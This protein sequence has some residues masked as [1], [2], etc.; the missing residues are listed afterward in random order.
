[1][2]LI[3]AITQLNTRTKIHH[4]GGKWWIFLCGGRRHEYSIGVV[5]EAPADGSRVIDSGVDCTMTAAG[6]DSAQLSIQ[7]LRL[8]VCPPGLWPYYGDAP[9]ATT[10]W[11]QTQ[12]TSWSVGRDMRSCRCHNSNRSVT[13]ISLVKCRMSTTATCSLSVCRSLGVTD[14]GRRQN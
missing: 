2:S 3:M 12:S 13:I 8:S 5:A 4:Y 14:S 1:M 9:T 6:S 10:L 7:L 11:Q